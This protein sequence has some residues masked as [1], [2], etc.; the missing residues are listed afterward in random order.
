MFMRKRLA[1]AFALLMVFTAACGSDDGVTVDKPWARASASMAN[2]GAAYM[3]L[4]SGEADRLMGASV[5]AS[6]AGKVEIHETTAADM[7]EDSSDGNGSEGMGAMMMQEVG[8]IALPAGETVALEP[9]GLHVMLLGL[10]VPLEVGD[11]FDLTLQ[12][13]NA[14][15]R[16]IEVEVREDAP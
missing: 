1:I 8:E 10:A 4:T 9:G 3:Q 7:G 14:G 5:D 13:E 2:A 15:D 11:T 12:F 16:V 6:V